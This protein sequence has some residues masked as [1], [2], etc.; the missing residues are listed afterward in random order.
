MSVIVI[1]SQNTV[2]LATQMKALQLLAQGKEELLEAVTAL[3]STVA[4][5]TVDV[6]EGFNH[7]LVSFNP[8][9]YES[10][11]KT[12]QKGAFFNV[13]MEPEVIKITE[14]IKN[15]SLLY[16]DSVMDAEAAKKMKVGELYYRRAKG[17]VSY[18]LVE[19]I[20]GVKVF[21]WVANK[22]GQKD[23]RKALEKPIELIDVK[24]MVKAKN[25]PMPVAA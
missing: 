8:D 23:T 20:D 25:Q 7:Y 16:R 10:D 22:E 1:N 6:D 21:A 5:S 17:G 19:R 11:V 13:R 12:I 14:D 15:A 3:A 4:G 2:L 24:G 9:T 18:W